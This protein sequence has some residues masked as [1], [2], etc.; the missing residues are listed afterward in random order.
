MAFFDNI[1]AQG[2]ELLS[3]IP[4]SVVGIAALALAVAVVLALHA[5]VAALLRRALRR[6]PFVQTLLARSYG[7][8]RL[9]LVIVVIAV[10]L[11][12]MPFDS[13]LADVAVRL[14]G[15]VFVMLL[16]WIALIAVDLGA[17]FYMRGYRVEM[18]NNVLA[19]KHLTQVR[20]LKRTAATLVVV[21]TAAAALMN[22][23]TVRQY[24][25]SLFASA[26]AAGLVV[27]LAA[28]PLFS[29]LIAG[30][31][32]AMTQPIRLGDA[33]IVENE[34]GEIEEITST[35]VV[36]RIWDLRRLIVPL[37]YFIEKPFQNWTRENPDIF[38]AVMIHADYAVPVDRVRA[39][40]REIVEASP[41]WDRRVAGLQ[42]T[43][44][45]DRTIEL[46]ALVS[47]RTAG[48]A[49]DLR[50]EVR[51]KLIAFLR[52]VHPEGLP[53]V[54]AEIAEKTPEDATAARLADGVA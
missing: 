10:L 44:A 54:R 25:V 40:L 4:G 7:P 32:L 13:R 53:H 52:E 21:V 6:R 46:R 12:A 17:A 23:E 42:V 5:V 29:N 2:L 15:V 16:G 38:G 37:T 24:G 43:D 45:T 33:V 22:F 51:E 14:L 39:K 35:Y 47:A 26:G 41:L 9:A 50:C 48:E 34:W 3:T 18:P 49:F 27:G 1:L 8:S 11:P 19:R 20:I 31:Q 30:V 28:R 36:V